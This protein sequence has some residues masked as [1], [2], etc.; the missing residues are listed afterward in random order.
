MTEADLEREASRLFKQLGLKV[1]A[2]SLDFFLVGESVRL[3]DWK[4]LLKAPRNHRTSNCDDLTMAE[5]TPSSTSSGLGTRP[6]SVLVLPP[7]KSTD[8]G[9]VNGSTNGHRQDVRVI[10]YAGGNK[11]RPECFGKRYSVILRYPDRTV[12][13]LYS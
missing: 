3:R 8:H 5:S 6:R 13:S 4:K 10:A 9:L 2:E 1:G 11:T 12:T 7:G